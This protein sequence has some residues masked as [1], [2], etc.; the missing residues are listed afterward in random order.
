[1]S[2]VSIAQI[3]RRRRN[4]RARLRERHNRQRVWWLVAVVVVLMLVV[5]PVGV[6]LGGVASS[7]LD[8]LDRLPTPQQTI[9]SAPLLGPSQI[10]DSSGTTL[11]FTADDPTGGQREWLP[12]DEL[13]PYLVAATLLVEDPD[14]MQ[15]T[16]FN[17]VNTLATLWENRL[18]GPL[19]PDVS[20]TGRL[21]RNV[22]SPDVV[23]GLNA[24]ASQID[25]RALEI[26]LVAEIERRYS[27]DEILEWHLNT[28][29]YGG[30]AYGID[31]AA[32][33]YLGKAARELTV[34]EAALLAA[35]PTAPQYNPVDDL[36]AARQ[37]QSDVL[38]RLLGGG[39]IT[40]NQFEA[41]A[42]VIT[43]ILPNAGQAPLIAPDFAIYARRQAEDI[44]GANGADQVARGG[45]RII[46]TL[47]LDLYYQSECALRAHLARLNGTPPDAPLTLDGQPC[48]ADQFIP[49]SAPT[50][51]G[52]FDP[53]APPDSG[54]IVMLDP[55]TG[56]IR[57]M[58][59]AGTRAAYQPGPVLYPFVYLD[60]FTNTGSTGRQLYTPATMLLD[61]PRD[62]PGAQAGL[63]HIPQNPDG[64][65]MGPLNLRE[66]MAMGR[67]PAVTEVANVRGI[68]NVLRN[69]VNRIGF[70]S[71]NEGVYN[72]TL[73]ERGGAVAPLDAAFAYTVLATQG[74]MN[75]LLI[76]Q[77]APGLRVHDPVAVRRIE[78]AE[79]NLIWAYDEAYRSVS[80]VPF[81]EDELAYLVNDIL[82]DPGPRRAL[83][84][85]ESP[86]EMARPTAIVNG[87]TRDAV[88]NWTVG[89]TTDTVTVVHLSREG[90]AMS[91]SPYA[92]EGA[93]TLWRTLYDY[94]EARDRL[95]LTG[96]DRPENII[97]L[98]VC[99]WSGLLPNEACPTRDEIFINNVRP[100]QPDTYWEIV[101]IN[102]LTGQRATASTN[103]AQ[104][105]EREYF[106]P[107]AEAQD[108]WLANNLPLPPDEFDTGSVPDILSSAVITGP[109]PLAWV[110]GLVTVNG[111]MDTL[112]MAYFQVYYGEGLNPEWLPLT[113][114]LTEF[115]SG[116]PLATWDTT[117]LDGLYNLQL[118]VVRTNGQR[119]SS[120]P[121]SVRVDN[122]AP[123]V[124]LTAGQPGQVFV[125]NVDETI[126]LRA[127]VR[128]NAVIERVVF[129]HNG[130]QYGVRDDCA[131]T[132]DAC[133]FDWPIN[134]PGIETFSIEVYDAA[135]N[136]SVA[137]AQVE[138]LRNSG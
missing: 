64:M 34:D 108:W 105:R 112:D 104:R 82:A 59:G 84:G 135:G 37:R 123:V 6:V 128:D 17:G 19:A 103:P 68:N 5:A 69:I 35:I 107:P 60:A 110:R 20:L 87:M 100:T 131:S 39:F 67:V 16:G 29:Y 52:D 22:I 13:P 76:Q 81:M 91:L 138:I 98:T 72:L 97:E 47:D 106:I 83:Y 33:L 94:V 127:Q 58:V 136:V 27:V 96:W 9:A 30:Q 92:L 43:Q 129:F 120:D 73:L 137:E 56:E 85:A 61:I 65:F 10:Y 2:S 124:T 32:R 111:G 118:V 89:Y 71:L 46:T 1:M 88:D 114:Q 113:G 53:T 49:G 3:I 31:A 86:F 54:V 57:S 42:N 36:S 125:W 122:A 126:P 40:Q 132:P 95:P 48:V 44:L 74:R 66:A 21:V 14:F 80:S 45:L 90:A 119:E 25:A 24:Q 28:N 11:L 63:L 117:G 15:T 115:T 8:A 121:V 79:G 102:A 12:L 130:Q 78:D 93:A 4:R 99:E 50:L 38:R 23:G 62:F 101:E 18:N 70:S 51:T 133:G 75:G 116:V 26:A 7:Y 55:R 41:A 77:A 109:E 134:R